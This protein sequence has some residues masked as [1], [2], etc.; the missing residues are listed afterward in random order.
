MLFFDL[1]C[2][3]PILTDIYLLV[4]MDANTSNAILGKSVCDSSVFSM[5][6]DSFVLQCL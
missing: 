2:I 3:L 5:Q 4:M 1:L 6:M